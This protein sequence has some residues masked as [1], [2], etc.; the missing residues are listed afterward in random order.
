MTSYITKNTSLGVSQRYST[1]DNMA[2]EHILE[3]HS[4]GGNSKKN[5]L[6][7]VQR[8]IMF[9]GCTGFIF[10]MESYIKLAKVHI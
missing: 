4:V 6:K 8:V 1:S 7:K 3:T 10:I 5:W 9:L 2:G